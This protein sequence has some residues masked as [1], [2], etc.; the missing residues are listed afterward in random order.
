MDGLKSKF[1]TEEVRCICGS[2]M[3]LRFTAKTKK[4]FYGCLRFPD[5]KRVRNCSQKNG[6]AIPM[7]FDAEIKKWKSKNLNQ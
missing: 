2:L 5:C 6:M 4:Y 7:S 3:K 1:L